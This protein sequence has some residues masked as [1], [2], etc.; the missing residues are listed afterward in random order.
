MS[1]WCRLE[2]GEGG[3][4]EE[5]DVWREGERRGQAD[6]RGSEGKSERGRLSPALR[7]NG[8]E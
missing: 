2:E 4:G 8:Q 1:L 5:G 6:G 7:S 3:R